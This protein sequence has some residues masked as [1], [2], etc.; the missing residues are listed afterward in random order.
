VWAYDHAKQL[1]APLELLHVAHDP[2][3]APGTYRPENGD[4]L[5]PMT[6]VAQRKLA[7]YLDDVRER[8]PEIPALSAIKT[9]CKSGLPV[10]TIL[11]TAAD[12]GAS[13]LVVGCHGHNGAARLLFGSTSQS[14][15]Q[16]ARIPVTIV[17]A[18]DR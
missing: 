17:K 13:L 11:R 3:N 1:D 14:V 5:E 7:A 9:H 12:R 15:A 6:D 8:H 2:A 10:D 18:N 4:P 16:K